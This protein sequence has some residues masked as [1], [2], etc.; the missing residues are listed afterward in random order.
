MINV[1]LIPKSD[2]VEIQYFD[3]GDTNDIIKIVLKG[4]NAPVKKGFNT[5]ARQFDRSK[6]GLREL[7]SFVKYEIVYQVDPDGQQD[8]LLPSALWERGY[9]DCKSKTVFICHVLKCLNIPFI[10]RF[11]SYT[12]GELGHVYPVAIFNNEEIIIDSVFDF[13]DREKTYIKKKDYDMTKISMIS[14]I[15]QVNYINKTIDIDV[16]KYARD[17]ILNVT[18]KKAY[19]KK[20]SFE[21]PLNKSVGEA[22]AFLL[23]RQLELLRTYS[24]DNPRK[25]EEYS[26]AINIVDK[27]ITNDILNYKVHTIGNTSRLEQEVTYLVNNYLKNPK[28][29][30][31][32]GNTGIGKIMG[33]QDRV[34]VYLNMRYKDPS[35]N[36]LYYRKG[37]NSQ[38]RAAYTNIFPAISSFLRSKSKLGG[39]PQNLFMIRSQGA[40]VPDATLNTIINNASSCFNYFNQYNADGSGKYI[41]EFNTSQLKTQFEEYVEQQSGVWSN[42]LQRDVFKEEKETGTAVFYDFTGGHPTLDYNDFSA[43]VNSKRVMQSAWVDGVGIVSGCDRSVLKNMSRNTYIH[44][45]AENPESSLTRLVNAQRGIQGI[46]IEP[47][48]IIAIIG[49]IFGLIQMAIGQSGSGGSADQIEQIRQKVSAIDPAETPNV[50]PFGQSLMPDEDDFTTS[51]SGTGS[52]TDEAGL[53]STTLLIGGAAALLGGYF[54]LNKKK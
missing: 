37:G 34:D 22:N 27:A 36:A 16:D 26:K 31:S 4:V 54:L 51:S 41:I 5:F 20:P 42:F 43:A 6:S 8:I 47:T 38:Y 17:Y 25:L 32:F 45:V 29:A 46:G 53:D 1:G 52:G 10:I 48:I 2:K 7:W 24:L 9:G 33:I 30:M 3:N 19:I 12:K 28:P 15:G 21:I 49:G 44:A 39:Q 50:D 23:K 11:T 13:F 35:T 40:Q 18:Q 14:G